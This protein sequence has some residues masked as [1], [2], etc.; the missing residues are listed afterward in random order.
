VRRRT[1]V[2]FACLALFYAACRPTKLPGESLG[3]YRITGTLV[4]NTCGAGHP[5][6]PSLFFHV[7]LR[8]NREGSLG[9]WKLPEGPAVAGSMSAA[10]AFRFEQR[11][12]VVAIAEDPSNWVPGCS[13][14]RLE[15]VAGQLAATTLDGGTAADA[16]APDA[17]RAD[18]GPSA[19]SL[20]G[21]TT[22]TVTPVAG[23]DCTPLLL[24]NGGAFPALP[25]Q[26]RWELTGERLAEPLW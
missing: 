19:A 14:E 26:L 11:T 18:A 5:A 3:Q 16:A 2:L 15:V 13:V 20:R 8:A 21:T 23:G 25:C 22:V 1:L 7:E 17:A 9:Y 12:Q 10:G 24:P 6:P 4:E